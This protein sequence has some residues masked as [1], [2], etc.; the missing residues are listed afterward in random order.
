MYIHTFQWPLVFHWCIVIGQQS[1]RAE[2]VR[3]TERG[4]QLVC[5]SLI[6]LIVL[7][8]AAKYSSLAGELIC[9]PIWMMAGTKRGLGSRP[10]GGAS[11]DR[12]EAVLWSQR[13]PKTGLAMQTSWEGDAFKSTRSAGGDVVVHAHVEARFFSTPTDS[14]HQ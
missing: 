12:E 3:P 7:T 5:H 1:G 8:V 9:W 13:R 11:G 14:S 6:F 2:P 4:L 10:S